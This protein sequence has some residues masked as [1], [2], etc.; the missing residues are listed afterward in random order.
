[1]KKALRSSPPTPLL[2]SALLLALAAVPAHAAG[3]A[4]DDAAL[5][6]QRENAVCAGISAP[7]ARANCRSEASTRYAMSRPLPPQEVPEVLAR[8]ALKR[9]ERLAEAD[10]A[11]C[12][13]RVVGKTAE[14]RTLR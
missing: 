2:L 9:C 5:R 3:R 4:T 10:R 12:V 1:M 13:M 14:S 11:E 8:N 7:E 6:Y